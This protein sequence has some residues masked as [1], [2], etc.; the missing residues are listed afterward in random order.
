M[1]VGGDTMRGICLPGHWLKSYATAVAVASLAWL[2]GPEEA[3]GFDL[4]GL[5]RSNEAPPS[6]NPDNLVYSV[7]FVARNADKDL[8]TILRDAS[9]THKLR[10]EP[11]QSAEELVRRVEA[12][13]PRLIDALWGA[14]YYGADLRVRIGEATI[15]LSG[16]SGSASRIAESFRNRAPVPIVFEAE[17]GKL[18]TLRRIE[19]I[20]ARTRAPLDPALVPPRIIRLRPGDPARAA[21]LRAAQVRILD[22]LRAQSRPHAKIAQAEPT[23]LHQS[24]EMDLVLVV[25]PGPEAGIGPV[26]VSGTQD[27]NPAVVRSFVHLEE[28]ERYSPR[29]IADTRKSVGRI[30]ALGS[31]RIREAE[32]LD[33]NGNVPVFVEV[34]ERKPRLFGMSARYSTVDGPGIHAYWAHRNLF[35]GAERLRLDAD[36]GFFVNNDQPLIKN[37]GDIEFDDFTGRLAASFVKPALWGSRKDLLVDTALVREKTVDYIGDYVNGTAAIRHRFNDIFSVQ[38]G[39]GIERGETR[40]VLGRIDYRLV[41]MPFG[42]T[43]DSTDSLLD[44]TQGFRVQ[45][46]AAPYAQAIGSSIDLF[47]S[48]VQASA[49]YAIDEAANYVLAG[50]IGLGS[51][52]GPEINEIP[53]THRFYAGGAGSVRGYAYRSLAPIGPFGQ[54]IGGRSLLDGSVEAR[55]KVTDTIGVVPFLDMGNAFASSFPDFKEPIRFAAGLGLRYYTA[56]GPIRLDVA[57]PLE[58]TRGATQVA[59]YVS[60][61]QA[62]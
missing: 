21:D 35:G 39:I 29:K 14:G 54:A 40:D 36:I 41:G 22:R 1:L 4:F 10:R 44:P 33:A 42:L 7:D 32:A 56:I 61:G 13:L 27:V 48:K 17:L 59:V 11:P 19:V 37:D 8:L 52:F 24:G 2:A 16:S 57:M 49:Y 58:R 28:G 26:T 25:D 34:T 47:E 6:P 5:F 45:A 51:L 30:E 9:N 18:F 3:R 15:G 55:I 38:G 12:D 20:D 62:F 31:V 53:T 43:Y 50:R 46:R 60:I 23:V